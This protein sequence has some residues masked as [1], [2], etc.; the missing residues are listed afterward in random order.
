M[1]FNLSITKEQS[2]TCDKCRKPASEQRPLIHLWTT[3][4]SY[5]QRNFIQVHKDCL[6]KAIAKEE[7]AA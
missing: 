2:D 3:G 1:A 6:L 7:A 5:D 4:R